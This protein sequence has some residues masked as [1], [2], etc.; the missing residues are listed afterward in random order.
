MATRPVYVPVNQ[1]PFLSSHMIEFSWNAGFAASQKKKN[2]VALHE[3][4]GKRFPDSKVLEISSK[5]L[6]E[7]GVKL[8]AFNLKK[9]V[10][11]LEVYIPVE[12]VFQG[13]KVFTNGGPYTDLYEKTSREAKKDER[14]KTSGTLEKFFFDGK[15]IP[16]TPKTAFYDW[17]Y[18]NSLLENPELAEGLLEYEAFTDIEFNPGKSINCQAKAAAVY[19]S[20]AKQGMLEQCKEF[21]TYYRLLKDG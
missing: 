4:Y 18:I 6:Q 17:I 20:L 2:I 7:L 14:L 13:G 8:S 12:C 1:A 15:E 11:Q 21:E 5:S 19:V 10:P 9:Y 3:A 16:S